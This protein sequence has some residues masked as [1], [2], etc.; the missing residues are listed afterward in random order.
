[1]HGL[2]LDHIVRAVPD[3]N[4]ACERFADETGVRPA[5]GGPHPGMGTRNALAALDGGTYVEWIGPDPALDTPAP[6]GARLAALGEPVLLHWAARTRD[7]SGLG[8]A[9]GAAG[10][11]PTPPLETRRER[12]DGVVLVW[13]LM[14][15]PGRGGAWPF[16][17]DWR[18]APHPSVDA[19][20]LGPLERCVATLDC[21]GLAALPFA[22]TTGIEL[23][24]GPPR[25]HAVF[26]AGRSV[27]EWTTSGPMGFFG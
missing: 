12:P 3:L 2:E 19:P 8:E 27:V 26:Q 4:L 14:G 17:I 7:M 6:M 13:D 23:E 16:F 25:L 22:A 5:E 18:D 9:L 24:A 15:L 11:D 10:L 20:Q 1:M 21:D